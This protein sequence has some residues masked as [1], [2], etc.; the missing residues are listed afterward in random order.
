MVETVASLLNVVMSN[1]VLFLIFKTFRT[2]QLDN[3]HRIRRK[4]NFNSRSH[5]HRQTGL[6]LG[7]R[8]L[9][10]GQ[11]GMLQNVRRGYSRLYV[12]LQH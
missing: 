7:D 6:D 12:R 2:K 1:E 10:V 5:L 8:I 11:P 9:R 3:L 4:N